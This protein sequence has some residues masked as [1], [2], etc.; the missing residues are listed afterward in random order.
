MKCFT[1]T[2]DENG[3][4]YQTILNQ[5]ASLPL[6][7]PTTGAKEQL[8]VHYSYLSGIRPDFSSTR[9]HWTTHISNAQKDTGLSTGGALYWTDVYFIR[10]SWPADWDFIDIMN[11][12]HAPLRAQGTRAGWEFA[13]NFHQGWLEENG[14]SFPLPESHMGHIPLEIDNDTNLFYRRKD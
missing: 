5:S 3:W 11:G 6:I 4:L 12:D 2:D 1:T 8:L 9:Y 13:V 7:G 14:L 10:L